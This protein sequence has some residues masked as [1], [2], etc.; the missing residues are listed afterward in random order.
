MNFKSEDI[1]TSPVKL[2]LGHC[3]ELFFCLFF[4]HEL[5]H[6]VAFKGSKNQNTLELNETYI[7]SLIRNCIIILFKLKSKCF[8]K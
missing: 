6:N 8:L 2:H 3:T 4:F 5:L 7:D 1:K